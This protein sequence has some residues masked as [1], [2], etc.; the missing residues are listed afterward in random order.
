MRAA[1]VDTHLDLLPGIEAAHLDA[2]TE[3]QCR[4]RRGQRIHVEALAAGGTPAVKPATVPGCRAAGDFHALVQP[5]SRRRGPIGLTGHI[6]L[7]V[8]NRQDRVERIDR[9]S[10]RI[11]LSPSGGEMDVRK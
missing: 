3:R 1:I 2:R 9:R 10:F 4:V 8:R 6:L 11:A 7:G 5:P